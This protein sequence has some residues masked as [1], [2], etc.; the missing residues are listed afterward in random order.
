M[1]GNGLEL[2]GLTAPGKQLLSF[3]LSEVTS[4]EKAENCLKRLMSCQLLNSSV[5]R[6]LF[7]CF[8]SLLLD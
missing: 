2:T 8:K 3:P 6:I 1:D 4:E 5:Q 7:V